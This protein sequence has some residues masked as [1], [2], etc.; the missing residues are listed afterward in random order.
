MRNVMRQ[1]RCCLPWSA[2]A[3]QGQDRLISHAVGP[4]AAIAAHPRRLQHSPSSERRQAGRAAGRGDD[5][6]RPLKPEN[7]KQL[8]ERVPAAGEGGFHH[9]YGVFQRG[10]GDRA[11]RARREDLLH[12]AERRPGAVSGAQCNPFFFVSSWPRRPTARRRASYVTSKG[13]KNVLFLAPN[14]VGG[15][16]AATGFKRY[17]KPSWWTRC[18]RSSGSSIRRRTLQDPRRQARGD[19]RVLPGG[20]G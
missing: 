19:V 4:N 16:D 12:R 15:K 13:I 11:G 18:I 8:A 9:R 20:M 6:R 1:S 7:A 5:R 14:Y 3:A 2:H 17:Y 10:A